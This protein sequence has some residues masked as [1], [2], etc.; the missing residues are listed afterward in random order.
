MIFV[1]INIREKIRDIVRIR[2]VTRN[3]LAEG[4]VFPKN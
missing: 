4:K 1:G 2:E 3:L